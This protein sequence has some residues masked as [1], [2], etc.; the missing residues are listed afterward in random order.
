M[1]IDAEILNT[2]L[3]SQIQHIKKITH[4]DQIGSIA[5]MFQHKQ[6]K[7]YYKHHMNRIKDKNHTIWTAGVV[8]VVERL[9]S[10]CEDLSS[11][12]TTSWTLL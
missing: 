11:N 3:T 6:I 9:P 4:H 10:K 8:Q 7:C 2:V 12:S 5:G 1:N